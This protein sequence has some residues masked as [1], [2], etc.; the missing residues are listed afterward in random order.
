MIDLAL[1]VTCWWSSR[2]GTTVRV[3]MPGLTFCSE[4]TAARVQNMLISDPSNSTW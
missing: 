1:G 2:A 3:C 4:T